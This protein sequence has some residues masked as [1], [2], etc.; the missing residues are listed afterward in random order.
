MD[1]AANPQREHSDGDQVAGATTGAQAEPQPQHERRVFEDFR[2]A[3]RRGAEDARTAAEKTI[4]KVKSAAADTVYWT[5]YG[6]S[7][8]VVFQWTLAKGLTPESLKSG[9]RDGVK[10][11]EE[12]ALKWTD[13]LRQRKEKATDAATG[14]ANQSAAAVQPG[15][16]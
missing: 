16:A 15:P 13:K 9:V 4:P 14:Q 6:V 1:N 2:D 7:F 8:A 10:A 11:A 12:A 3:I 5:A